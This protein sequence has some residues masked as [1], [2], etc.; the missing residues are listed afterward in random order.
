M[1][2]GVE[3][4]RFEHSCDA[5]RTSWKDHD[6]L[7]YCA[8]CCSYQNDQLT[9][10]GPRECI[11]KRTQVVFLWSQCRQLCSTV[12]ALLCCIEE[13]SLNSGM[14]ELLNALVCAAKTVGNGGGGGLDFFK[15]IKKGATCE[16]RVAESIV[17]VVRLVSGICAFFP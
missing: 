8:S 2:D 9:S 14:S 11:G 3:L 1:A 15:T 4:S 5:R 7:A 12:M 17:V 6:A 10:G 13:A 16:E